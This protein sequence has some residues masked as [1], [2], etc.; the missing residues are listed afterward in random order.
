[1]RRFLHIDKLT[2]ATSTGGNRSRPYRFGYGIL[3][4]NLNG[5]QDP[6]ERKVYFEV[7]DYSTQYVF[8]AAP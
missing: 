4:A 6:G 2:T 3:D 7:S 8:Y 5:K 1:M